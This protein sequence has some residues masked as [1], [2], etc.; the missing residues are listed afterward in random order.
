MTAPTTAAEAAL[1]A[2]LAALDTCAVS[3]ALDGF[4]RTGALLGLRPLWPVPRVVAG[5]V[6]TLRVGPPRPDQG[7]TVHLGTPLIAD[8]SPGDVVVIDH[9]GRLD[10]SSWGGILSTAASLAGIGGVVVDGACRDIGES[11]QLG[12]P[13]WGRAVVPVSARGR[14]VQL[15]MDE[16]VPMAGV[17]VS[18]GDLVIADDCGVVVLPADV[19]SGV[20]DLAERI[21]ARETDMVRAVRS[22]RSVVDVMHDSQF[23]SPKDVT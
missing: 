13:V 22:G 7:P 20:V 16:T 17:Q 3:D 2:R 12:L 23:P 4:G 1:V 5:R 19:A 14:I 8:A 18:T 9:G 15:G 10:V 21:A 11:E 6:R